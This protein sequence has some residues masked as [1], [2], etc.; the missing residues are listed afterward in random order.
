M[1]ILFL[2]IILFI[3][4]ILCIVLIKGCSAVEATK[5]CKTFI[6]DIFKTLFTQDVP[7]QYFP[8]LVGYNETRI[9]P[10]FVESAF[11]KISRNFD[12]FYFLNVE[13]KMKNNDVV[14]YHFSIER[15]TDSLP[16]EKLELLLQRQAEEVLTKTMHNYDCYLSAE[17]LTAVRLRADD[18]LVMYART[19]AGIPVLDE[20]KRLGKQK[21]N[22]EHSKTNDF[23]TNWRKK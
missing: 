18:F 11:E 5:I 15:K 4:T 21:Y 12:I 19:Q 8:V 9:V 13:F 7:P 20:L 14:I 1:M 17:P 22:S 23:T 6:A 2:I 16:D 10:Q 3:I